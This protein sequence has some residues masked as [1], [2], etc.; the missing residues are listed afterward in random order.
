MLPQQSDPSQEIK[1]HEVTWYSKLGAII[2]F[3]GVVPVLCFYI[4]TQYEL[5]QQPLEKG[6][7]VPATVNSNPLTVN[8]Y[9]DQ[10]LGIQVEIPNN[11]IVKKG[12]SGS[13]A[14]VSP[15]FQ[16]TSTNM[17]G[18]EFAFQSPQSV[19]QSLANPD[20]YRA[21]HSSQNVS[22][23][24]S[25]KEIEISGGVGF[26]TQTSIG[27]GMGCDSPDTPA[28]IIE[29]I[30]NDKMY[31]VVFEYDLLSTSKQKILDTFIQSFKFLK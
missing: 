24:L 15:D 14:I 18:A 6:V 20:A 5:T 8:T 26:L 13:L 30:H 27:C 28:F 1:W 9:T 7:I 12:T 25:D 23:V 22:N 29:T 10:G 17:V 21:F 3:L 16:S 2:L 31:T 11:W 4:G 19:S